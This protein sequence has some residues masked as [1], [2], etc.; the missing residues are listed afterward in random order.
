MGGSC[1]NAVLATNF[2][3]LKGLVVLP[4][5]FIQ[6]IPCGH[7]ITESVMRYDRMD[8]LNGNGE[9]GHEALKKIR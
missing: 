8:W 7:E 4:S 6:F 2:S 5:A 3:H 1:D 9:E